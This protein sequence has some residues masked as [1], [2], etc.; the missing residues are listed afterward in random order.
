M[1]VKAQL[2]SYEQVDFSIT[3]SA[4]VSDWRAALAQFEGLRNHGHVAWPLLGLRACI[5]KMLDDLD[6]THSDVLVRG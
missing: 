6:R 5:E 3:L 1:N 4:P 2:K